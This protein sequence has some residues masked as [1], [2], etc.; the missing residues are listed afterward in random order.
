MR[1]I[2]YCSVVVGVT[3]RLPVI[4]KI[5]WWV[6]IRRPSPAITKRRQ[7]NAIP[8]MSVTNL[9]QSGGTLLTTPDCRTADNTRWSETLVRNSDYLYIL[10]AFD[11]P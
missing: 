7:L 8:A 4:N 10:P 9:P 1:T 2:K 6:A 11:G 3:S 5:H